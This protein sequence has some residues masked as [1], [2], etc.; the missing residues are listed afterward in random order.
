[1]WGW[2]ELHASGVALAVSIGA[3]CISFASLWLTWQRDRS[4]TLATYPLIELFVAP[5]PIEPGIQ[6][7][8]LNI[9]NRRN[10]HMYVNSFAVSRPGGAA[11]VQHQ[12]KPGNHEP[13]NI[14]RDQRERVDAL[15]VYLSERGHP[16]SQWSRVRYVDIGPR[17]GAV[18]VRFRI[19]FDFVDT[20][21]RFVRFSIKT[22][23]PKPD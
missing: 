3:L 14:F 23:V 1:M 19:E 20:R 6:A 16:G 8:L 12:N 5:Y 9:T 18:T 17:R 22:K 11:F 10:H 4:T 13:P 2:I 21:K 15:H 7:V